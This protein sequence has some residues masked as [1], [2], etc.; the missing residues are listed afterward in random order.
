[1]RR[2]SALSPL[3]PGPA[4][5]LRS[6]RSMGEIRA[7]ALDK[8]PP[9]H[10]NPA[11]WILVPA[12]GRSPDSDRPI[13]TS[14]LPPLL[15]LSRVALAPLTVLAAELPE[16]PNT[17]RP[18]LPVSAVRSQSVAAMDF[19]GMAPRSAS[20]T[21]ANSN[22][23]P[24]A[25]SPRSAPDSRSASR[26]ALVQFGPIENVRAERDT[27]LL[28]GGFDACRLVLPLNLSRLKDNKS[29]AVNRAKA[30]LDCVDHC[31]SSFRHLISFLPRCNVSFH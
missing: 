9:G 19:D 4:R 15:I 18:L 26:S 10:Q 5:A 31:G 29:D 27:R 14:M 30:L 1:M 20:A 7:P 2:P 11:R 21:P 12:G 17:H 6:D 24:L 8:H 13:G 16:L 23:V 22:A 28:D 3:R 25:I